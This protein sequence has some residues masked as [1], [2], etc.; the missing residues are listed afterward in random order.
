[1]AE[2]KIRVPN[3]NS[4]E[5]NYHHSGLPMRKY[6]VMLHNF[7]HYC[8][9]G[10]RARL[11]KKRD[12]TT[13]KVPDW[14]PKR[15]IPYKVRVFGFKSEQDWLMFE[16]LCLS[17]GK[18]LPPEER[19]YM[20]VAETTTE[21]SAKEF[22]EQCSHDAGPRLLGVTVPRHGIVEIDD[23]LLPNYFFLCGSGFRYEPYYSPLPAEPK[24]KKKGRPPIE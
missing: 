4:C 14:C 8:I 1:M 5:A 3:C 19:R 7:E 6:G 24:Q 16:S 12:P 2:T 23:G 15:I 18:E 10:K 21:V 17:L 22:W 9:G 20:V 13:N 11:F